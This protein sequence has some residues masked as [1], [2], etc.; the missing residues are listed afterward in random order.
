MSLNRNVWFGTKDYMQWIPAPAVDVQAGKQGYAGAA[1]FLGGGAWVRR[2]KT[3]AKRYAMSWNMKGRDEVRPIL[4]YADGIYGNGFMYYMD[5]FAMD[6]NV[7]PSY[8]AAPYMNY[9]DGPFIVDG[10]RPTLVNS[11]TANGYPVESA[12]YKLTSTSSVPTVFIPIP[13]NHVAYIGAHG[14]VVTGNASVTVTPVVSSIA[15][16]ATTDLTLLSRSTM[17]R[18]NYSLAGSAGYIGVNVSMRSTST[19]QLQLDGLIAQVA[20]EGAVLPSGGFISGQGSLGLSFANQPS[21]S[22]YNA[23]LDRVGVSVELVETEP[24]TWQ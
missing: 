8:V 11:V 18:T 2:S 21:Y 5:P 15:T 1:S 12:V 9:Y 22:E 13:Q 23:A 10:T 4:D 14:S 19:G 7:F 24:W 3:A 17:T 6:K 20:P 16:G